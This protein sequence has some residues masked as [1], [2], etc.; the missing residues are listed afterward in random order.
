MAARKPPSEAL[1]AACA[2]AN[3]VGREQFGESWRE[4]GPRQVERWAQWRLF[5]P[6]ARPGRG[7]G[8]GRAPE[9]SD[10]HVTAI[11]ETAVLVRRHRSIPTVAALLFMR[12]RPIPIETLRKSYLNI[13][14]RFEERVDL[15][16]EK[17]RKQLG[18]TGGARGARAEMAEAEMA[19]Q[20]AWNPET[21]DL[22][23]RLRGTGL[24]V[25][26]TLEILSGV[27]L[28]ISEAGQ[29]DEDDFAEL[30][31]RLNLP[32]IAEP[33]S[34]GSDHQLVTSGP[35]AGQPR[36]DEADHRHRDD[37][38]LRVLPSSCNRYERPNPNPTRGCS[39]RVLR[40]RRSSRDCSNRRRRDTRNDLLMPLIFRVSF[41]LNVFAIADLL[42][43]NPPE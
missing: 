33:P 13:F 20:L 21:R 43:S 42:I 2:R 5:P 9:Y 39:A 26:N 31:R 32:V 3:E 22:R 35:L 37:G 10:E 19:R 25:Q 28:Q 16:A 24:G 8:K 14:D 15:L 6:V 12:G 7:R 27:L 36:G 18:I 29:V 41:G 38:R 30:Q 17:Q 1:Q 40:A 11:V 34:V 23:D 4:L